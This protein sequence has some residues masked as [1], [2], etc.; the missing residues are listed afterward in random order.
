MINIELLKGYSKTFPE[1]KINLREILYKLESEFISL[2]LKK[3]NNNKAKAS[4]LLGLERTCLVEKLRK[5][6]LINKRGSR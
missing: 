6:G 2:A 4:E 3:T 1:E 5:R